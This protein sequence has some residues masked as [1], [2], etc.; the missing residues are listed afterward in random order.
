M[1]AVRNVVGLAVAG[2]KPGPPAQVAGSLN[3]EMSPISATQ[4]A[5]V[6]VPYRAPPGPPCSP[7][8]GLSVWA[9]GFR[10]RQFRRRRPPPAAV[11]SPPGSGRAGG[12]ASCR[13]GPGRR[14]R[15]CRRVGQDP[16]LSHHRVDLGLGRGPQRYEFDGSARALSS[17]TSGGATQASGRS[18]RH[19]RLASSVASLIVVLHPSRVPVQPERVDQVHVGAM[20]L[21]RSAAQY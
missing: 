18:P 15:T 6:T 1:P 21:S 9:P 19:S 20:A 4:M 17:R 8:A 2:S 10:P 13:A 11:A 3:R 14:G 16:A 7:G 12:A 5:A